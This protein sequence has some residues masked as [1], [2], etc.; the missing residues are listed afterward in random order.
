MGREALKDGVA[1]SDIFLN[2]LLLSCLASGELER[3]LQ[4]G[5]PQLRGAEIEAEFAAL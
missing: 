5:L 2:I 4:G 3:M 1:V